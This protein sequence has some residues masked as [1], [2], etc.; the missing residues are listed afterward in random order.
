MSDLPEGPTDHFE[1]EPLSSVPDVWTKYADIVGLR[2]V[3][4]RGD[5][6]AGWWISLA[7][8]FDA[9]VA[10]P[11][12]ETESC[13]Y[14]SR[15][16]TPSPSFLFGMRL[17]GLLV[18]VEDRESALWAASRIP[19]GVLWQ[20]QKEGDALATPVH[21]NAL[22]FGLLEHAPRLAELVMDAQ[23]VWF[24]RAL[25]VLGFDK[26]KTGVHRR[27]YRDLYPDPSFAGVSRRGAPTIEPV[28]PEDFLKQH[29]L[30]DDK[31]AKLAANDEELPFVLNELLAKL[32]ES[33]GKKGAGLAAALRKRQDDYRAN[34]NPYTKWTPW[35]R[36]LS[37]D[38][39]PG[40][41]AIFWLCQALWY[42]VV[43][44]KI[45]RRS[46]NPASLV[47]AVSSATVDLLAYRAPRSEHNGQEAL[48]FPPVV[49]W[50]LAPSI[51]A[52]LLSTVLKGV[53]DLSSEVAIDFLEWA[54]TTAHRQYFDEVSDFRRIVVDRGWSGL[55]RELG[56]SS[57]KAAD[58]V[59]SLVYAFA[60]L[61]YASRGWH[62]NLLSYSETKAAPGRKA[63]VT[64]TLGDLLLPGHT[65][66]LKD[67]PGSVA[68]QAR[69]DRQLVPVLGRTAVVGSPA[70]YGAQRRM[71][72]V[73]A[74]VLRA[75]AQELAREGSVLLTPNDRAE[76]AVRAGAPQSSS[77]LDK[78]WTAWEEGD[79]KASPLIVRAGGD[80][81]TLHESRKLALDFLK[82]AGETSIRQSN[83]GQK[84]VHARGR[85]SKPRKPA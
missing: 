17:G 24:E 20:A 4:L 13:A 66:T 42:D 1:R 41:L 27:T 6:E 44:P 48:S 19:K 63:C 47:R 75:R 34:P 22:I 84:A 72:W 3:D 67:A 14:F 82:S 30:T 9:V 39:L 59:K 32:L 69:E 55:G 65:F 5:D 43:R 78:V 12:Y 79:D 73:L 77:L 58:K 8:A 16:L 2:R 68:L 29:T 56:S 37:S 74:T 64:I 45:V 57:N 51:E 53:G 31:L 81:I 36:L 28:L 46:A 23:D 85:T 61:R 50:S 60:H 80:R 10:G 15:T 33:I 52:D 11:P 76:L 18:H 21:L 54:I 35:I 71:P 83:R 7:T 70:T 25:K 38:G 26:P 49:G 40:P 62:G